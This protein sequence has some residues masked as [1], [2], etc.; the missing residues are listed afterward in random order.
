[1]IRRP[2]RSTLFPYTTLFRSVSVN[3]VS[4]VMAASGYGNAQVQKYS[5][6][7]VG[8][9]GYQISTKTLAPEGLKKV[10]A[11]LETKLGTK[12]FSSTSIG[13]TFGKTVANSAII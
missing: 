1:M 12:N 11:S 4:S 2:P 5:N 6:K 7:S 13:P 9:A 10:R 3:Q 8:G